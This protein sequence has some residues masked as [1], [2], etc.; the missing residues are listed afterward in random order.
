MLR[1]QDLMPG[2]V[3]RAPP[4]EH[5]RA[6]GHNY[7]VVSHFKLCKEKKAQGILCVVIA[8]QSPHDGTVRDLEY[9][10]DNEDVVF[11]ILQK[12]KTRRRSEKIELEPP[13][14]RPKQV[15]LVRMQEEDETERWTRGLV[16][17]EGHVT[18][19]HPKREVPLHACASV[20]EG[21]WPHSMDD[22]INAAVK[23]RMLGEDV[24]WE[25]K[26][27]DAMARKRGTNVQAAES[28]DDVSM[29]LVL[30]E[31]EA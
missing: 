31:E 7:G 22:L 6:N 14:L 30:R 17:N 16:Q 10:H 29:S 15:V 18:L 8:V 11:E 21:R 25:Q 4:H 1:V 3:V 24:E 5:G 27:N 9:A 28:E 20:R 23:A 12:G 2:D 19:R 26:L 13:C